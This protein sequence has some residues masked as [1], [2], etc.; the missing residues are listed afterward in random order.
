MATQSKQQDLIAFPGHP[1]VIATAIV[2]TF[3]S[4]LSA[5]AR[6]EFGWC[7]AQSDQR[8]PGAGDQVAAA[9]QCLR[10]GR[11]G[12]TVDDMV[13]YAR[14]A[15]LSSRA[16]GYPDQVGAGVDEADRIEP[17]FRGLIT[18]DWCGAPARK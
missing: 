11:D 18:A 2:R 14:R 12:G 10:L 6:T 17:V 7:Q 15:W 8:I 1:L 5:D 13:S 9:M 4:L 3:P 16:G